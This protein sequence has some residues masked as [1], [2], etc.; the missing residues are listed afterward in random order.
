MLMDEIEIPREPRL[1]VVYD[2]PT[3]SAWRGSIRIA[4]GLNDLG[5]ALDAIETDVQRQTTEAA[6]RAS[7]G[8]PPAA[9][10]AEPVRAVHV[11][12]RHRRA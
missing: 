10:R 6:Q 4:T 9:S 3:W 7:R 11:R 2:N 12:P 5:V 1:S 8:R